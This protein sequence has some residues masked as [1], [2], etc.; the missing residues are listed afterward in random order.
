MPARTE[1]ARVAAHIVARRAPQLS[2]HTRELSLGLRSTCKECGGASICAHGKRRSTCKECG[3]GGIC[4]H[5]KPRSKCK[6]CGGKRRRAAQSDRVQCDRCQKWRRLPS[7]GGDPA[8]NLP[9]WYCE[10]MPGTVC[11][12]PEDG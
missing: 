4:A 8:G 2:G 11:D 6:E 1:P 3:G 9:E 7:S 10:M 5:G 12:Q